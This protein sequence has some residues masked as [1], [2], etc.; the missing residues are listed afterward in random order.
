M[1]VMYIT[2]IGEQDRK[3]NN[4]EQKQIKT[5]AE[6]EISMVLNQCI[7]ELTTEADINIAIHNLLAIINNYFGADR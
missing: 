2:V 7:A 6:L 5:E 1:I 4:L 3:L